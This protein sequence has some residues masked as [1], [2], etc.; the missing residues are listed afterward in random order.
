MKEMQSVRMTV[1]AGDQKKSSQPRIISLEHLKKKVSYLDWSEETKSKF[2][3]YASKYPE[4]S[5]TYLWANRMH[6][7]SVVNRPAV[8]KEEIKQEESIEIKIENVVEEVTRPLLG[9][10]DHEAV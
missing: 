3:E 1:S 9:E 10:E 8:V 4:G 6:F 5:L 7:A 2:I